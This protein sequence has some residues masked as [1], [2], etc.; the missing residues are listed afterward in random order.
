MSVVKSTVRDKVGHDN[1][2]ILNYVYTSL[3]NI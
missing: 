2:K 1:Y 3:Q